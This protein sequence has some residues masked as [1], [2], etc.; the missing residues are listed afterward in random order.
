[1]IHGIAHC[2]TCVL[3][4]S[5][6][7]TISGLDRCCLL[8]G[9]EPGGPVLYYVDPADLVGAYNLLPDI[10]LST[11]PVSQRLC[12]SYLFIS[13]LFPIAQVR[14]CDDDTLF[15]PVSFT[16]QGLVGVLFR[17]RLGARGRVHEI[18][19]EVVIQPTS[20]GQS[21]TAG[22]FFATNTNGHAPDT[23]VANQLD[24]CGGSAASINGSAQYQVNLS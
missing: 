10:D 11:R 9:L 23:P 16:L 12:E 1:M 4:A 7:L 21:G 2:R 13:S 6:D 18:A 3:P 19:C 22:F 17:P 5:I 8:A 24:A 15:T 14:R 20:G